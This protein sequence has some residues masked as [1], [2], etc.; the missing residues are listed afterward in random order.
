MSSRSAVWTASPALTCSNRLMLGRGHAGP[1]R[2][3]APASEED[4]RQVDEI[5]AGLERRAPKESKAGESGC[6]WLRCAVARRGCLQAVLLVLGT[7]GVMQSVGAL[8]SPG[9]CP[10]AAARRRARREHASQEGSES[11]SPAD[12]DSDSSSFDASD[13]A[14]KGKRKRRGGKSKAKAKAGSKPG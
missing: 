7:G 5:L 3:L 4:I 6:W 13:G 1:G 14:V 12:S 8:F 10:V 11:D 9:M 2:G